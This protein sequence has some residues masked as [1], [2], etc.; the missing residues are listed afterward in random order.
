MKRNLQFLL[1]VITLLFSAQVFGQEDLERRMALDSDGLKSAWN[2]SFF[3]IA[4][5]TASQI[6][7]GGSNL[8]SYNYIAGNYRLSDSTRLSL[9]VPFLFNTAG[10]NRFGD[11]VKQDAQLADVFISYITYDLGYIGPIDFSGNF[12]LYLPTSE[13]S[14]NS[15]M[16]AMVRM[17]LYSEMIVGRFSTIQYVFKPRY[18][19][20]SQKAYFDPNTATFPDGAYRTS[21][22]RATK[23]AELEHYVEYIGDINK[24]L[25][26]KPAIGFEDNWYYGSG[27]EGIEARRTTNAKLQLA[28]EIRPSRELRFTLGVA[29]QPRL[30]PNRD[31][32]T[33]AIREEVALFRPKDNQVFL[34][35][36]AFLF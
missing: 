5:T 2:Y 10:F 6:D 21:P 17:D 35:T 23:Q 31:R 25:S 18:Y 36:N 19:I 22:I 28:L 13:N 32:R 24:Y 12:R 20:Q 4:S 9:R 7:A 8:E 16:I 11:S 15:R 29:N 33:G 26:V 14:Q 27:E 30:L 3:S 34:M 1:G